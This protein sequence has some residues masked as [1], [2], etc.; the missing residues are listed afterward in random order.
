MTI[1]E[2]PGLGST[3][4][5]HTPVGV[6]AFTREQLGGLEDTPAGTTDRDALI[7]HLGRDVLHVCRDR[8]FAKVYRRTKDGSTVP[9]MWRTDSEELGKFQYA[10]LTNKQYAAV[11]VVD[12]DQPG[13]QGGHPINLAGELRAKLFELVTRG[14]GPAWVGINRLIGQCGIHKRGTKIQTPTGTTQHPFHQTP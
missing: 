14:L 13:T 8:N 7:G 5:S 11:L 1:P 2:D 10:M 9:L 4:Q 12:I 6:A 3:Q